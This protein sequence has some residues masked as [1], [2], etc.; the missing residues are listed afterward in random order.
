MGFYTNRVRKLDNDENIKYIKDQFDTIVDWA[1]LNV[2]NYSVVKERKNYK[3]I[4]GIK[5]YEP[6]LKPKLPV[7]FDRSR[8]EVQVQM[9]WWG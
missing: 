9:A 6:L 1:K 4:V 2:H 7:V 5:E 8:N 3:I